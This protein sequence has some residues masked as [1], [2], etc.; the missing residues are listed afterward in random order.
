MLRAYQEEG[1]KANKDG[2]CTGTRNE[3]ERRQTP[4]GKTRVKDG[5]C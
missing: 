5:K 4:G 3:M 1:R 2:S